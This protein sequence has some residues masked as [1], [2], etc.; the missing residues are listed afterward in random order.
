MSYKLCKDCGQPMLPKGAVKKPNEYDHA[1]GCPAAPDPRLAEL[2]AA[3][4]VYRLSERSTVQWDRLRD[5]LAAY[6]EAPHG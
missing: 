3:G 6:R 1:Q 5:A 4:E 2:I